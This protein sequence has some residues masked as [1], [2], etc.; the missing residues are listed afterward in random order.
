M[1]R[2][3][4]R[5]EAVRVGVDMG[6]VASE[7]GCLPARWLRAAQS[8]DSESQPP[9]RHAA[10]R[11]QESFICAFGGVRNHGRRQRDPGA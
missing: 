5:E 9:G 4:G 8:P 2:Q 6:A 11:S 3:C 1:G 7:G 10:Q